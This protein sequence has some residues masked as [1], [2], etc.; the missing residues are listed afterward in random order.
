[1]N[2]ITVVAAVLLALCG[3]KSNAQIQKGN[4]LLGANVAGL[5]IG[6]GENA[7]FSGN[8][9]PNVGYFFA[10]KFAVAATPSFS[11][12]SVN[13]GNHHLVYG[14]GLMGRYYFG[15]SE[16][17][18]SGFGSGRFF[19]E[20][21]AAVF[22]SKSY[23][24]ITP[25]SFG[26]GAGYAYFINKNIALEGKLTYDRLM[27]DGGLQEDQEALNIS[28]GCQIHLDGKKRK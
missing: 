23:G 8:V 28:F 6:L 19:G 17:S 22:K 15:A 24:S 12:S 10:D 4:Y 7:S 5:H 18:G 2:K 13:K 20:A 3:L 21:N 26:L 9:N 16:I 1:M 14:L 11:F 25:F 27:L